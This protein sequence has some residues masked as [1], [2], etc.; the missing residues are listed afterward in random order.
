MKSKERPGCRGCTSIDWLLRLKN[1]ERPYRLR[2]MHTNQSERL[3]VETACMKN[4][5]RPGC[6]GCTL[7]KMRDWLPRLIDEQKGARLQRDRE[8]HR[9][10]Q[11]PQLLL[12][13]Q[14]SVQAKMCKFHSQFSTLDVP[15]CSK[16]FPGL[17]FH[18]SSTECL[19]CS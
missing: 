9:E 1:T 12:L 5:E 10:Q 2:R 19:P 8:R 17:K 3:A 11:Q 14:P 15:K 4:R 7:L 18:S 6:R 13:E 16:G